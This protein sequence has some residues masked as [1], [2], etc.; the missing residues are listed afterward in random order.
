MKL[1]K[2][3]SIKSL[4]IIVVLSLLLVN[5]KNNELIVHFPNAEINNI[6]DQALF[7]AVHKA[8]NDGGIL[9]LIVSR[10]GNIIAAEYFGENTENELHPIRSVTKTVTGILFGIAFDKGY[11]SNT[12]ETIGD[13]LSEYLEPTDTAI[14][15]I[16]IENLLSMTGGFEWEE[17]KNYDD[18]NDW[19][20]S[21][22]HFL[23]ALQVP[24]S[25]SPGE[26]FTY[27]TPACQ[28]LSAIFTKAT[29]NSLK[30]FAEE[31][32][33]TPLNISGN[34]P[35]DTDHHGFNYGGVTL[36]LCAMDMSKIGELYLNKGVYNGKQIVSNQWVTSST[37]P[38]IS[39]N[40][41]MYYASQYGYLWWVGE[42]DGIEYYFANGYGGQFIFV[43]PELN[44][45]IAAQSKLN[46]EYNSPNEQ[47]MN[48][49]SIIMNDILNS[50]EK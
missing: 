41:S 16:S 31:F 2:R 37:S 27:S 12:N 44:L 10:N 39:V 32:L 38:K 42:Q 43:F 26:K 6:N 25:H 48:T 46:N 40:N 9:S 5:C 34:R 24:L 19:V 36:N 45:T 21:D 11:F 1:T 3:S 23:Y 29:G 28:I 14:A 50:V 22:D 47:W 15:K 33:L 4:I 7:E 35:W 18:F 17:L 8:E 13:Y 30:T 20:L 49:I